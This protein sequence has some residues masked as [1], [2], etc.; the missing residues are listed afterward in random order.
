MSWCQVCALSVF[1]MV[2]YLFHLIWS[3][4][5]EFPYTNFKI[6]TISHKSCNFYYSHPFSR[7]NSQVWVVAVLAG[8]VS[9]ILNF[10]DVQRKNKLL[11]SL[12]ECC[13][14]EGIHHNLQPWFMDRITIETTENFFNPHHCSCIVYGDAVHPT[15]S[16]WWLIQ[17]VPKRSAPWNKIRK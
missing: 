16:F 1:R 5:V 2:L 15:D 7:L 17:G 11:T 14:F 6:I 10:G 3:Y 4:F 12:M 8:D 9:I 13:L